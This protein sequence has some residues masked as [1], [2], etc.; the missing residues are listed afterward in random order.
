MGTLCNACEFNYRR[1]LG[2]TS[3]DQFDLDVLALQ[4]ESVQLS[5]KKAIREVRK[6]SEAISEIGFFSQEMQL[7]LADGIC[8]FAESAASIFSVLFD[9]YNVA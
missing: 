5:I 2:K 4:T 8:T 7:I 1:E 9:N 6:Q 3:T